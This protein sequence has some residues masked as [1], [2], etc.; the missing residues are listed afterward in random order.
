[1]SERRGLGGPGPGCERFRREVRVNVVVPTPVRERMVMS[2]MSPPYGPGP[3]SVLNVI[4]VDNPACLRERE[5]S[6][7]Q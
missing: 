2:V 7:K 6:E 1:M 3:C 5:R 4:K